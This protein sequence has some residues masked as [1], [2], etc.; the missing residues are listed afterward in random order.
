MRPRVQEGGVSIKYEAV[1]S[2]LVYSSGSGV[3]RLG[4]Q[5]VTNTTANPTQ[6]HSYRDPSRNHDYANRCP[7]LLQNWYAVGFWCPQAVQRP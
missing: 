2:L 3:Q 1:E 5:V 6:T 7:Q 4:V